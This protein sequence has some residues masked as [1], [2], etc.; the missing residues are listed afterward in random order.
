MLPSTGPVARTPQRHPGL[1]RVFPAQAAKRACSAG[2]VIRT[3]SIPHETHHSHHLV[4][5]RCRLFVWLRR[6]CLADRDCCR[7]GT[8][9]H[10]T[11][12]CAYTHNSTDDSHSAFFNTAVDD[13]HSA[14][15][16]TTVDAAVDDSLANAFSDTFAHYY[17]SA[18]CDQ[19]RDVRGADDPQRQRRG[20]GAD[21]CQSRR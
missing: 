6:Q 5:R 11:G 12:P 13:S 21:C 15:F 18:R 1:S 10:S 2:I 14:L 20:F 4:C 16:N 8:N 7:S 3:W 17:H 19:S 9:N